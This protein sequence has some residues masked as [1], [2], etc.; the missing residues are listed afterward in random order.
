MSRDAGEEQAYSSAGD[1]ED[2]ALLL[3]VPS[4][5]LAAPTADKVLDNSPG[6][7]SNNVLR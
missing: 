6:K 5:D 3:S 7:L 1:E 2:H 4:F